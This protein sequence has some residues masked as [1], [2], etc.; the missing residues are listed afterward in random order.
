MRLQTATGVALVAYIRQFQLDIRD[1][2]V[3]VFRLDL[4]GGAQVPG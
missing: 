1:R 4:G 2:K 3:S